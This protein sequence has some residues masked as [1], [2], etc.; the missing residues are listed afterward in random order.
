MIR[1]TQYYVRSTGVAYCR[2]NTV[3]VFYTYLHRDVKHII[4]YKK[5]LFI[6]VITFTH[7]AYNVTAT[8][9]HALKAVRNGLCIH[10]K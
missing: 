2:R 4:I 1:K 5:P 6:S 3:I 8:L 10:P 9:L 7:G